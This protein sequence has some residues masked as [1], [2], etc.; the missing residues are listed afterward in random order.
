M[1]RGMSLHI[2]LNAVDPEH[3]RGWDGALYGCEFDAHDM[4]QLAESREFET[5]KLLTKA[6]K[7]SRT[8]IWPRS[9][10]SRL[11]VVALVAPNGGKGPSRPPWG[12]G[13]A[14]SSS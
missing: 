5:R 2:G 7:A 4:E 12:G 3:Y 13:A 10:P 8:R 11:T 6:P 1:T 9:W 14:T